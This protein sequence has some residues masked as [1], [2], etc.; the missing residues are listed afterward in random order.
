MGTLF[1]AGVVEQGGTLY[2][3]WNLAT[4]LV[5]WRPLLIKLEESSNTIPHAEG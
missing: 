1:A 3:A 4:F 5:L 2:D